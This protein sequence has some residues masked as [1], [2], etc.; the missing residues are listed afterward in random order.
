MKNYRFSQLCKID[1][2]ESFISWNYT[3]AVARNAAVDMNKM[4]GNCS[5]FTQMQDRFHILKCT[6]KETLPSFKSINNILNNISVHNFG[7]Q[8]T[9][10]K[11]TCE[12]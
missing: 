3:T 11:Q 8:I 6:M 4:N 1:E 10:K 12:G 9:G 5:S 2:L 7:E